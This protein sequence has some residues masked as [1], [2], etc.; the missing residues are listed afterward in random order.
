MRHS[1][2]YKK[3]RALLHQSGCLDEVKNILVATSGGVDSSVLLHL[4]CLLRD[5]DNGPDIAV[6][7]VNH[8]Q[9]K[10]ESKRDEEFVEKISAR[11]QCTFHSLNSQ[12]FKEGM[13]EDELR[14]IRRK[15]LVD[16]AKE[17]GFDRIALGHHKDDQVETFLFRLF[18]GADT[19]GLRGMKMIQ[20]PFIRPLLAFRRNE[21]VKEAE[22]YGLQYIDDS[23]NFFTGPSRNFIRKVVLP[24]VE[25]KLDPQAT[26]HLF[27]LAS[28][29]E[30]MERYF[31]GQVIEMIKK[32]T[33]DSHTYSVR[34]LK[35]IPSFLR[36]K[37]ILQMFR[38]IM[39]NEGSLSRDH[40]EMI[41]HWIES[42]QSPKHLLLPFN[43]KVEKRDGVLTFH[44]LK[45]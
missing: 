20:L 10:E 25:S 34:K 29:L 8:F 43:K 33:V 11:Y 15:L 7:H 40:I 38:Y 30:E 2:L 27:D 35:D 28:S 18:R 37:M 16:F 42:Q 41:D 1:F 23:S 22:N 6:A 45:P 44:S 26:E 31:D 39:D 36:K 9:R 12:E 4:F 5:H 14:K 19:K 17:R 32:V 13:S 24:V 21:L 3:F